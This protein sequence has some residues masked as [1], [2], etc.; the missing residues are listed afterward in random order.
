MTK[1]SKV[2]DLFCGVGGLSY[3][4]AHDANFEIVAANEILPNMAKA[5]SLNHPATKVYVEDIKDFSA[6][7][8]EKDLNIKAS[9]IDI[10]VG[11]PPCQAYSTVGKRLIDDPRGKLFQEYYR[12][13]KEFNPKLFLFEN[14]KGLLSMQGGELLETIISLFESLGYKVQYRLLNAADFG[15]PQ[16]RERVIIIGSKLKNDFQYPSQ[17]HY[18]TEETPDLF[19]NGLKPHLTLEEAISDLPFIKSGE[20]SFEYTSEPQNEFQTKMRINAPEKLTDHNSPNNNAKLVKMMELLPDGGTPEDLPKELRPTSGF[21]NTYC[22]LWWN[23][24][25]TTI[26]RNLSTPSS[27]RCI[28]P[29]APRPLTTREGARIQCFPDSYQFYGSRSDRNLQIG[30]AVPTFLS[31]VMAEAILY[32]FKQEYAKNYGQVFKAEEKRN[33]VKNSLLKHAV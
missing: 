17:T 1:K 22:R 19:R 32:N 9:E 30:N 14:V 25:S 3:G 15:T 8:I 6:E 10:I 18:S 13:L 5:Y 21:K 31:S 23:R 11:G 20:E 26:T 16:I 12:V 24:P 29:K 2:I 7:K 27:S 4:F 28:H 33:N